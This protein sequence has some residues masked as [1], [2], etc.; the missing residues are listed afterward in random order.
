VLPPRLIHFRGGRAIWPISENSGPQPIYTPSISDL[1]VVYDMIVLTNESLIKV[2]FPLS[3]P[4]KYGCG[5]IS[6]EKQPQFKWLA[7]RGKCLEVL[8]SMPWRAHFFFV[9]P[10]RTIF[11]W[12]HLLAARFLRRCFAANFGSWPA[13]LGS[14]EQ[15]FCSFGLLAA[16]FC[17]DASP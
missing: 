12:M 8:G 6:C 4:I 9:C 1:E 17:T 3:T 13:R 16:D 11:A 2:Y 10:A 15:D 5:C 14:L 7:Q